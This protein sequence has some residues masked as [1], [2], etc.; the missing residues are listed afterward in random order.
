M[1]HYDHS[2][3][4]ESRSMTMRHLAEN[5]GCLSCLFITQCNND[6]LL[7]YSI[8]ATYYGSRLGWSNRQEDNRPDGDTP[9]TALVWF[10][11]TRNKLP[12]GHML[13]ETNQNVLMFTRLGLVCISNCH[14]VCVYNAKMTKEDHRNTFTFFVGKASRN[15]FFCHPSSPPTSK[16]LASSLV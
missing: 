15:A 16:K 6:V 2:F 7:K 4:E 12:V 13:Q 8:N 9:Q 3:H 1:L 11:L 14:T 5:N 10:K